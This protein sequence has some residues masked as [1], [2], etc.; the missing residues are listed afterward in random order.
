MHNTS[1]HMMKSRKTYLYLF[2]IIQM[3]VLWASSCTAS[4]EIVDGIS[5]RV[6]ANNE[7]DAAIKFSVPVTYLRHFPEQKSQNLV[8][9]F[10]IPGIVPREQWLNVESNRTAT[11]KTVRSFRI[12]TRDLSSGPRIE[13]EF[14]QP[15]E[16]SVTTGKDNQSILVHIKPAAATQSKDGASTDLSARGAA[17]VVAPII[18]PV[19]VTNAATAAVAGTA[20][21]VTAKSAPAQP[22]VSVQAAPSSHA[23]ETKSLA[24]V[25]APVQLGGRD[26][27]PFFPRIDPV[28]K[29]TPNA[30]PGE[31]L[32]IDEQ[33]KRSNNQAA[34]LMT[35]ARDS[36]SRGESFAAIETLNAV[37]NL[38]QNKYS[39]DAQLWIGIAKERS[40]QPAKAKLE[41]ESYLKLYPKGSEVNWVNARLSK[42]KEAAPTVA[43]VKPRPQSTKFE[44]AEY[45]SLSMYYYT[46][47]SWVNTKK[48]L[49]DGSVV[50]DNSRR[51]DQSSF[52]TS[53]SM[54]ARAYNNVFDNR[55]VFQDFFSSN[56]L[57]GRKSRNRPNAYYYDVRNRI[58]N[59]SLRIGQQSAMGGG[60]LGRFLGV[61]AGYGFAQD[62]RVNV[63]TGQMADVSLDSKPRFYSLGLD[64]GVNSPLGG[65]VYYINQRN[66]GITDR[67]ATGGNLRYFEQGKT[68]IAM[69]D[70]DL[71][72]KELNMFTLQGT[73]NRDSGT[74][75]NFMLDR[76]KTPSLSAVNAVYGAPVITAG[77]HCY[78]PNTGLQVSDAACLIDQAVNGPHLYTKILNMEYAPTTIALLLESGYTVADIVTL[79]KQRTAVSNMAQMGMSQRINEKWQSGADFM[80]SNT[81]GTPP[82]GSQTTYIITDPV[83]NIETTLT[84]TGP[85]GYLGGTSAS[86]NSMTLSG[87]LSASDFIAKRD[88]STFSLSYTKAPTSNSQFYYLNNRAF[89]SELWTFDSTLRFILQR[90]QYLDSAS[91]LVTS[92]QTMI[93]PVVRAS[94]LMRSNL[95]LEGELGGDIAW[96]RYSSIQPSVNKRLYIS[97]GFRWDF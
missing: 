14:H 48:T 5:L 9:Y 70:Y 57:H 12:T 16:Y 8:I 45:G 30:Q 13:I 76:R 60:V 47:E 34:V 62:W 90:T 7:L 71:Q 33:I 58:D 2:Q 53:L 91:K 26:G 65:S 29:E 68:L 1:N 51:K 11:S 89:T 64:F 78:D 96:L 24:P 82:S 55:L 61:T 39:A 97:S 20:A 21:T 69:T 10:S 95:T 18:V 4:A 19:T 42:L 44:I 28:T 93:S 75:F 74:D 40:G 3:T 25:E 77:Q 83:T 37:L 92:K 17:G 49:A 31:V 67:K 85:E 50:E 41:Y 87:R 63:S 38:P 23:P 22:P 84:T 94:Y 86:G 56:L 43:K 6:D 27:L 15:V 52:I 35:K 73:L 59:Y 46:G 79:A 36:L 88:L 66:L 72:F 80:V 81:S 54:T 32:S